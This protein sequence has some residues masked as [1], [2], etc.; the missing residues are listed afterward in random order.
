[1]AGEGDEELWKNESFG[2]TAEQK[3]FEFSHVLQ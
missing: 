2:N 3:A 1:M